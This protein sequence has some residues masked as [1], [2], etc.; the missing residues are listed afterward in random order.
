MSFEG[1][2]E[3]SCPYSFKVKQLIWNDS[4]SVLK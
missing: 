2:V 4:T 1:S 3:E